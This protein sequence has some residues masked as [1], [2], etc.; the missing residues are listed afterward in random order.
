MKQRKGNSNVAEKA[1]IGLYKG[2]K[3]TTDI[4]RK[5]IGHLN[6]ITE[7]N[8]RKFFAKLRC[9]KKLTAQSSFL[10]KG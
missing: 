3:T 9:M 7:P 10:E 2:S 8:S 6:F 4:S 5:T 1:Q